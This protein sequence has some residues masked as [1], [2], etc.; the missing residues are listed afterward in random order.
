M[1]RWRHPGLIVAGVVL[2]G[3]AIAIVRRSRPPD[4]EAYRVN[5]VG[6]ARLEQFDYEEA[7][8]AFRQALERDP[9]LGMARINL[10][11]A[12]LQSSALEE[13]ERH[14]RT[15]LQREPDSAHA[16]YVLGLV[17][18]QR[19][20]LDEA[21]SA[22]ARVAQLDPRD[23]GTAVN[24]GQ[25]AQE[26]RAYTDAIAQFTRA[27][28]AEP[29]NVTAAYGLATSLTRAGRAQDA[30]AAMARF[31]ELRKSAYGTV[32][33]QSYLEQGRYAEAIVSTGLES[34]LVDRSTPAVT[35]VDAT[36]TALAAQADGPC[37]SHVL[38]D[39]DRDGDLDLALSC[40]DQVRVLK[41]TSGTFAV[42][43]ETEIAGTLP[44]L[45]AAGDF[46][47]DGAPDLFVGGQ[48]THRLLMQAPDG[49]FADRTAD[50]NLPA[51][52]GRTEAL[53]VADLDHDG[54]VDVIVG[55]GLRFLRNNGNRT[56][57]DATAAA[58]F[59]AAPAPAGAIV[60][61]DFDDRRDTDVLVVSS[62]AA[63]L[64]FRNLR[65]GRFRDVAADI[66]LPQADRYTAVAIGDFN[67]DLLPDLFLGRERAPGLFVVSRNADRVD[68][69]DA[70]QETSGATSAMLADYDRDGLLDLIVLTP[71]GP[72]AW[73]Y[74][75]DGWLDVS[76]RAFPP[77]LHRAEDPMAMLT[78]GDLDG[79]ADPD[80]V[81]RHASG[82]LRVLRNDDAGQ[83]SSLRVRLTPRVS[84]RSAVG[85][86]VDLRA[87]ALRQRL[88]TTSSAPAATRS[89]LVFGLGR[90]A[91]DVVRVLW[92]AGIL[93]AELT[94]AD[95]L[96][97]TELD[98]KPSS[99]PYLYSWNGSRFE[100]VTDFLGGGEMGLWG[101]PP[102]SGEEEPAAFQPPSW[103]QPDADEYVRIDGKQL[104]PLN[105]RYEI[106]VTNELEEATFI[107]R[108]ELIAID[109]P[110]GMSVYPDEGL[111]A[112][113][114][115]FRLFT[116]K[117]LRPP[118]RAL[119]DHGHDVAE[120]LAMV[121]RRYPD[122]FAISSIRGY[123][124]PHALTVDLGAGTNPDV[125]LLTGWTDYA[126]SSDHVA[127]HQAGLRMR[128]PSLQVKDAGGTWRTV[129]D[130]MGFPVGRPQTMT[131]GLAG[132]F[133]S[134]S[135]EVRIVTNMRIYWDQ[136]LAGRHLPSPTA[137]TDRRPDAADLRW[138]GF[139]TAVS[140]D[141]RD[142]LGFDYTR[143]TATAPW[144]VLAGAYTREGDVR[145]LLVETDNLFVVSM[146]GDQI[147][148]SWDA[149][150]FPPLAAD[151]MRTFLLHA[152]GFSK[153]MNP[154][155]ATPDRLE[156]LPFH[157]MARYPYD[158]ADTVP[159]TPAHREYLR[160]YQ[161]RVVK[162]TVPALERNQPKGSMR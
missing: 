79:D 119:D 29:Y 36:A 30:G 53:A 91:A 138:R 51:P 54:D 64:L 147:A 97:I 87:G 101:P 61:T 120:T 142:P 112:A 44:R 129:I 109:H 62:G 161:T 7:A 39:F 2:L 150:L 21:A 115:P 153:E 6:V 133:L 68:L 157:G 70:P 106:R 123:A 126:F 89:D 5:N 81:V 128:P 27:L 18:R 32:F 137:M 99:C 88:E 140:P 160:T 135:R 35:Y 75:G 159:S 149:G 20:Q 104:Q 144:K 23:A 130:D 17:L 121:D 57:T 145:A 63:P 14:V 26:R 43:S 48:P 127:A 47:N 74:L 105:G 86:K 124:E 136:I 67:K 76:A 8:Q 28:D 156:P 4:E 155:S 151:Q 125:L 103:N 113:P 31:E 141:G 10:A 25:I 102:M 13:A 107:D 52:S 132:R 22:F 146:P 12:L 93:Q 19:D 58:G 3:L 34:A 49:V 42:H 66:G 143:V 158:A 80:V 41:N 117:E 15:V 71:R 84:N 92:P 16:N 108:L 148:V 46:E 98:R 50:M 24:L 55:D 139:S 122:D 83:N 90:R 69:V 100:F 110:R 72:R 114:K 95:P 111:T 11:I 40:G 60:A 1:R 118:V 134:P 131:V 9:D 45:L 78:I 37:S 56:F 33:S 154:R 162:R 38:D 94:P 152:V 116:L 96:T 85:A 59:S 77:A 65:D 73:R 82:R